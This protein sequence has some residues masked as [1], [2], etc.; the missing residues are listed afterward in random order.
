M[1]TKISSLSRRNFLKAAGYS[2]AAASVAS[3]SFQ[4]FANET[5]K[6]PESTK[7]KRPNILLINSDEHSPF[8]SSMEG[9][10]YVQ[11]PNLQK[12]ANRGTY[13]RSHYTAS[14]LCCPTR[15]AWFAG[16]RPHKCQVYNNSVVFPQKREN[17][18]NALRNQGIYTIHIGKFDG[19]GKADEL[20]FSEIHTLWSPNVQDPGDMNVGRNPVPI[21]R[22]ENR[23]GIPRNT[24]YGPKKEP[25]KKDEPIFNLAAEWLTT[26]GMELDQP[27]YMQVNTSIPHFPCYTTQELWD[28]YEACGDLPEFDANH[29]NAKHP[30]AQSLR[31]HF[32]IEKFDE[33]S[34]RGLRR[35]YAA[36]SEWID[37]KIGELVK[38]LEVTGQLDNTIIIYTSDH[39]AMRGEFGLQ[40]KSSMYETSARVPLVIAGPGFDQSVLNNTATDSMDL[41][42][43]I[44]KAFGAKRPAEWDGEPI[45]DLKLNDE[46][47]SSF[48]EYH[49]HGTHASSY[50]VRRGE[51]KYVYHY[52]E[53]AQLMHI[54]SDPREGKDAVKT[55]KENPDVVQEMHN[56]LLTYLDPDKEHHRA[57]EFIQKQL[58]E[59]KKGGFKVLG[60]GQALR[61]S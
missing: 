36:N 49:G 55:A 23:E 50:L 9:H 39:G 53:P 7:V 29:P 25:F 47:R 22:L 13:Y 40:W 42:A 52:G 18:G 10:P 12:L 8:L 48:S 51:W 21:R 41:Q 45:Q 27:W 5:P 30:I 61:K 43:T 33:E 1:T 6:V 60:G 44:F 28:K 24:M 57:E 31:R 11:T 46:T 35:G 26:K 2:A 38:L 4:S 15:S 19:Y 58:A 14:P 59:F 32:Q 17:I 3:A 20:G 56:V 54:A 34:I 37:S 16:V